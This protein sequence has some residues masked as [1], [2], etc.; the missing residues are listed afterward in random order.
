MSV[1]VWDHSI[2]VEM[3]DGAPVCFHWLGATY[4]VQEIVEVWRLAGRWWGK[5]EAR[6][7]YRVLTSQGV[8]DIYSSSGKWLIDRSID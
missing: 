3:K 5:E 7:Y 8:F 2:R 1:K 6:N 4:I